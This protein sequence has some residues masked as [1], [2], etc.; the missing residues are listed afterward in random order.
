[1]VMRGRVA[2][3]GALLMV[4]AGCAGGE[5]EGADPVATRSEAAVETTEPTVAA[6]A[7]A[8]SDGTDA[9]GL[10]GLWASTDEGSA[11]IAYRFDPDGTFARVG[12]L[13]QERPSGI[14]KFQETTSGTFR[15][16]GGT[17]VLEPT[18]GDTTIEDPDSPD[19]PAP[20]TRPR[21]VL[22]VETH[23]WELDDDGSVLL[24]TETT[25]GS[26]LSGEA[27]VFDRQQS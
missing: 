19:G 20:V 4:V 16:E 5:R 25:A 18:A 6:S 8:S 9:A 13:W 2:V 26:E 14:W 24:L 7:S 15:V 10:V 1:M 11:E 17:L 22:T 21:Q 23:S 12:L 27:I 3:V